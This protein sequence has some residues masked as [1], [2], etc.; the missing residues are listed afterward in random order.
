M[1]Q[2]NLEW[3]PNALAAPQSFRD[4]VQAAADILEAA[5]YDPITVNIEVGY[6]EFDDGGS[7]YT[8]LSD[9]SLGGIVSSIPVSYPSLIA[10]LAAN[11][12]SPDDSTAISSLP[13]TTALNGQTDFAISS[14]EAKALGVLPATDPAIDGY[15]G[16]P[17]S[18]TGSG[19]VDTAITELSHAMGLLN[20][21]GV[22]TLVAYTS[23]G[24]HLLSA[25]VST[26]PAYFSIDGGNT[27]LANFDVGFDST[28]FENVSDDPLNVPSTGGSLTPLDLTM[29]S[30]LGFDVTSTPSLPSPSITPTATASGALATVNAK[31]VTVPENGAIPVLS[32]ITSVS[33]PTGDVVA[34]YDFLDEGGDN[35]HF[36]V[37]GV[38]EPDDQ[39]IEVLNTQLST[40]QYV[41]GSSPGSEMLFVGP[42]DYTTDTFTPFTRLTATTVA[43]GIPCYVAGTLIRTERGDVE[44]DHLS[45]NDRV[46]TVSG[47]SLPIRWIGYRK[48]RCNR[49]PQP[50]Q[51]WPVRVAAGGF[52]ISKPGR[53]LL[54]S[55]DHA[56]YVQKMLVPI[57]SLMNGTTITQVSVDQV[58]YYHVE[59]PTHDIIFAEGLP[60]ES[61]LDCG[62][63]KEFT[64]G[65]GTV[66]MHP[67]FGSGERDE[68]IWETSGYAP[69]RVD[70]E[71][72]YRLAAKLRRRSRELGY[73]PTGKTRQNHNQR[74]VQATD[75]AEL[76]QP[77]WYLTAHPD[78][79]A[80][81]VDARMHYLCWGRQEGRLPC[82]D[83]DL[84]RALGLVDPITVAIVMSDVTA[85][86]LDPVEH[87]CTFGWREQ[88]R[89]NLYFDTGWYLDTYDVPADMNPLL[90]YILIGENLGLTPSRHFD[91]S[92]YRTCYD[93]APTDSPLVHYLRHRRTQ[94][95]TP[96]PTF[97]V[98]AYINEHAATIRP[99]RDPYAHFLAIGQFGQSLFG[100]EDHK[101]V[102]FWATAR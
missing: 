15:V 11:E 73:E 71:S 78:V 28:L 41:G 98:A 96:L 34:G 5:I 13:A 43:P 90:H 84:V 22:E 83:V 82:P 9:Y 54:L 88:R 52:G 59:L 61:Y 72:V 27:N 45:I 70:G 66:Q 85:A 46:I 64:N 24:N 31:N 7:E 75:I 81:R 19:L 95:Y 4:G 25:G 74:N 102:G 23:P 49:H 35:G 50:E 94:R 18:F 12:T 77:Q 55:P 68:A 62:N 39:S 91:P 17:T 93:I 3:D 16:F 53:D 38:I 63:R 97:D 44:V 29:L 40:L 47:A 51:V 89:P 67:D 101:P 30:V 60:C 69:L 92:W 20:G 14:A 36:A 65:G 1:L 32:F 87:F 26:T 6:G 99:D 80:A 33:A 58:A 48:V 10:A 86:G 8:P 57:R 76:L 21:S 37:A 100:R 2:I 56:V 42:F 79:A